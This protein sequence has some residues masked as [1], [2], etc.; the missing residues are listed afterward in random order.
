MRGPD[1]LV[2]WHWKEL[3]R[4]RVDVYLDTRSLNGARRKRFLML[5]T[6]ETIH[7]KI[8]HAVNTRGTSV[9]ATAVDDG[10][11]TSEQFTVEEYSDPRI[12]EFRAEFREAPENPTI[13]DHI[14]AKVDGLRTIAFYDQR[15]LSRT[16]DGNWQWIIPGKKPLPL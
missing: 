16:D 9:Q 2:L 14:Q 13:L 15:Q 4:G 7:R 12:V 10:S 3:C 1:Y 8:I 6:G 5:L 11:A